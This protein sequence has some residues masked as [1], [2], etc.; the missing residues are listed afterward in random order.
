MQQ[1]LINEVDVPLVSYPPIMD[2]LNRARVRIQTPSHPMPS[3]W[4][5]AI[6]DLFAESLS[7]DAREGATFVTVTALTLPLATVGFSYYFLT[8]SG[9]RFS[10][11]VIS[12]Q[13]AGIGT[14]KIHLADPLPMALPEAT[15]MGGYAVFY[16]LDPS[17]VTNQGECIAR[18][19]VDV[20]VGSDTV[21]HVWDD[22]FLIVNAETNY[23]LN[24][25]SLVRT[26]PMVDRLRPPTDEDLTEI[27]KTGWTNYLRSDLEGKG[28]KANQIKSWERL[29]A[30]HAAACVYHLVLT[31]ERQDSEYRETWRT[32]YAH[33]CDLMFASI[34]FWYSPT[35]GSTP[36]KSDENYSGR[37]ISR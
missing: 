4:T 19:Q 24:S 32:N 26:Y 17:E 28:I 10:V 22:P 25:A 21:Q 3:T 33:Q 36:A 1:I 29:E 20:R 14:Y 35:D 27:I 18:W 2:R 34:R 31:D 6:M 11:K 16:N 12:I 5:N 13:S 37:S 9:E 7:E 15:T 8:A 23:T 30:A